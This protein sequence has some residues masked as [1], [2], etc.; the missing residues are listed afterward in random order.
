MITK[1]NIQSGIPHQVGFLLA[2]ESHHCVLDQGVQICART[3]QSTI[4]YH[5]MK[6]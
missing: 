4:G 5:R 3:L 2:A 6:P 1:H